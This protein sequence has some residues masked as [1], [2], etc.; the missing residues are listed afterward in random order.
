MVSV[1]VPK[2]GW[3]A[4]PGEPSFTKLEGHS[5]ITQIALPLIAMT[6]DYA[7]CLGTATLLCPGLAVTARHVIEYIFKEVGTKMP[8]DSGAV[9]SEAPFSLLLPQTGDN[10][11]DLFVWRSHRMVTPL[12]SDLTFLV[13]APFGGTSKDIPMIRPRLTLIPPVVGSR[14]TAFGYPRSIAALSHNEE[15]E[16]MELLN[17][18]SGYTSVGSVEE[19][20][21]AKRDS[22]MLKFPCFQTS[23]Q[24]DGGMSGGPVLD[25]HGKVCGVVCSGTNGDRSLNYASLFWPWTLMPIDISAENTHSELVSMKDMDA[26]GI[27]TIEGCDR[28][29]GDFGAGDVSFR[30]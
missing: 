3:E 7:S 6:G 9:L 26:R 23:S 4:F 24:F 10:P 14:I 15:G 30:Y 8:Q 17:E 5:P 20:H 28:V 29:E 27:L 13:T 1:D 11:D 21:L 16:V 25:E 22:G 18:V 12:D 19:V 2:N